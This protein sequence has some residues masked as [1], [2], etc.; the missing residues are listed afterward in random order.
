[1][2]KK[3]TLA[4]ICTLFL[5]GCEEEPHDIVE[6]TTILYAFFNKSGVQVAVVPK[7][8]SPNIPDSLVL[9]NEAFHLW[10]INIPY[11]LSEYYDDPVKI[12]FNETVVINYNG[13][14]R[15]VRDPRESNQYFDELIMDGFN[16]N[17]YT[18]T[19]EDYQRAVEQ[20]KK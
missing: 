16:Y 5:F 8:K 6:K 17:T 20:N 1:M 9:E 4:F 2:I 11:V 19:V 14:P 12:Y 7:G 10:S 13:F 15:D 18:F 3:I